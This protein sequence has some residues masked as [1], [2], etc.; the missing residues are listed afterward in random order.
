MA[1]RVETDVVFHDS[2]L[3]EVTD[4]RCDDARFVVDARRATERADRARSRDA[5]DDARERVER[6]AFD[7]AHDAVRACVAD[8]VREAH[9]HHQVR[10]ETGAEIVVVAIA[11]AENRR[12]DRMRERR[13]AI[14]HEARRKAFARARQVR[15]VKG[16]RRAQPLC[17]DAARRARIDEPFERSARTRHDGL[18]R[19]VLDRDADAARGRT[20]V[21]QRARRVGIGGHRGHHAVGRCVCLQRRDPVADDLRA[22]LDRIRAAAYERRDLAEAVPDRYVGRDAVCAQHAEHAD[23]G[24]ID[25]ELEQIGRIAQPYVG[26]RT[27]APQR[28]GQRPAESRL[29][30]RI[31]RIEHLAHARVRAGQ[32]THRT[33]VERALSRKQ[34]RA[35]A[36]VRTVQPAS[37]HS[38]NLPRLSA[39]FSRAM[40]HFD[41]ASTR[42]RRA[43]ASADCAL[44]K[45]VNVPTPA[46]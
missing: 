26:C 30:D 33:R 19:M 11:A 27:V 3:L 6:A 23:R 20:G 39:S 15:M 13:A 14:G 16:I 24:R 38:P 28:A 21:D 35:A 2:V 36:G 18:R 31:D 40:R 10:R 45:S 32:F 34:E 41:T 5:H 8:R 7:V 37:F 12:M 9:R 43:S 4:D 46:L 25:A 29:R 1:G 44:S 17:R 42:C 22:L